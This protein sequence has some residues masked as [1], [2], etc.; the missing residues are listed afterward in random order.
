VNSLVLFC[1]SSGSN[2]LLRHQRWKTFMAK[3]TTTIWG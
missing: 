2:R 1:L 3:L